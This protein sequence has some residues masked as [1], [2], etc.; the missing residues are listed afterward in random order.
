MDQESQAAADLHPGTLFAGRYRI[1]RLLGEG[2]RKR[3]Y[4]ARDENLQRRVALAVV[5]PEAIALDRG[6]TRGS[7]AGG[8]TCIA[9]RMVSAAQPDSHSCRACAASGWQAPQSG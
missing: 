2:D 4:L 7:M 5:K 1:E 9:G 6:G 3:T 8:G